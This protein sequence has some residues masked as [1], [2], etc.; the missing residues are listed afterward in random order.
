MAVPS[1]AMLQKNQIVVTLGSSFH[2]GVWMCRACFAVQLFSAMSSASRSWNPSI[3]RQGDPEEEESVFLRRHFGHSLELLKKKK[4]RYFADRPAWDPLRIAYEEVTDGRETYI[5]K[6]WRTDL[7]EPRQYALLRGTLEIST[8]VQLPAEPL[9]SELSR[10]LPCDPQHAEMIVQRLQ[11][12]VAT[13]PPAEL[14]PI[15]WS[16]EDPQVLFSCLSEHQLRQCVEACQTESL[17]F[18]SNELRDFF[19]KHQQEETLTLEI[20]HFYRPCFS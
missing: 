16:A 6:S 13:F 2:A 8:T 20:H 10:A 9:R 14:L 7:N 4:D 18:D 11:R 3:E 12:V 15:Y 19:V 5:L 1:A 17:E